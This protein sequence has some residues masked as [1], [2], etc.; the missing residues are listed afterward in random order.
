MIAGMAKLEVRFLIDADGL[1]R[2]SA[3][4]LGTG[5]EQ[6]IDVKPS[7][8]LTDEEVEKMLL[9]SFENAEADVRERMIREAR[10]DAER[11][12]AATERALVDDAPLLEAGEAEAIRT[13]AAKVKAAH[14]G[15]DPRAIA[16]A[17]EALEHAAAP[18]VE[19]RMN[20]AI[21]AAALGKKVEDVAP[22]EGE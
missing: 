19:R 21:A 2:V 18:F 10:V 8:G 6:K 13:A 12:L 3:T 22:A 7:Y 17:I 11:V 15:S 1:L 9:D 16:A 20:R 4:E 5:I 14:A